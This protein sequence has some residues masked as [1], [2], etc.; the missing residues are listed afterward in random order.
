[1]H[2]RCQHITLTPYRTTGV[3]SM[4][5]EACSAW[6]PTPA[7]AAILSGKRLAMPC[8]TAQLPEGP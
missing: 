3:L 7:L 2:T 1:M 8:Q 5:P 4:Q 6:Q